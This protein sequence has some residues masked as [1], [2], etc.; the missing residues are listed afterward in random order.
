MIETITLDLVPHGL[1]PSLHASQFDKNR[2]YRISL[3]QRGD[4]YKLD[5]TE[6]LS[7]IERKGDDRLCSMDIENNFAD[8]TY[9]E[10]AST[11]QMCAVWGANL[12]QLKISKGG[13]VLGLLNFILEV[14]RAPDVGGVSCNE[15]KNLERQ[16]HDIVVEE[17]R[18]NGAEE[19]GYDNTESEL[20]ATNVQDAIDELAQKPSV[21]AYTKTE[22]DAFIT[23]EYDAT[24]TYAIGDMVIHENALYVCSTA[25]TTAEAWNSSHW[26]LTDI[27]T[28]IG[29]VK[30]AIPTKT[31]DLQNDSGY[32]QID[33]SEES[34]SKTWSSEKIEGKLANKYEFV[35]HISVPVDNS[36]ID[37]NTTT[38]LS[39]VSG[40]Y[41]SGFVFTT[42]S[43]SVEFN[44][45]STS[46][47]YYV[48]EFTMSNYAI[49]RVFVAF[50]DDVPADVYFGYPNTQ[51]VLK[52][53]GGNLKIT[54]STYATTITNVKCYPIVENTE[55]YKTIMLDTVT[56]NVKASSGVWNIGIGNENTLRNNV[57]GTRCVAIGVDAL[58]SFVSGTRNIAIGTFA[59]YNLE[60]GDRNIAIGSDGSFN[61]VQAT[62]CI[63]IGHNAM[64]GVGNGIEHNIA[65]GQDAL[66]GVT[67]GKNNVAIG[68]GASA[69]I[70][71]N[72]IASSTCIGVN[73]GFRAHTYTTYIGCRAGYSLKGMS[74]TC[75]G[76]G[77]GAQNNSNGARNTFIGATCGINSTGAT[78]QNPKNVDDSIVIGYG[79]MATKSNQAMF[80]S[81]DITEVVFCGNKKINFNNDGTVT[82]ETLT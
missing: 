11:E 47:T 68:Y 54:N 30:S 53:N 31:S 75:I 26:T 48:V 44:Q 9:I 58:E 49:S 45:A 8:K 27:A 7:I 74:N 1:T 25:I 5:G 60:S 13:V 79:A 28:A 82:W 20:D 64:S 37:E 16:V 55:T 34:A 46:G 66:G 15:Y 80:G 35:D 10:F 78:A 73:A 3:T 39:N 63:S 57:N 33:D 61:N 81:T 38:T 72:N 40:N 50:G 70:S 21:D 18:D 24:S 65:I 76:Y 41:A 36:I 69:S 2:S 77:A 23:D 29:T 6:T 56:D 67:T 52:G 17:L 59:L 42:A 71:N 43:G 22:S 19:T 4:A 51:I 32:A 12:C 14:Q 62:D